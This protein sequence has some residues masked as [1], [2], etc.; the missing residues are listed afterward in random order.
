MIPSSGPLHGAI[1]ILP[2]L[3]CGDGVVDLRGP[4]RAGGESSQPERVERADAGDRAARYTL[5][6]LRHLQGA[7]GKDQPAPR[8]VVADDRA[9]AVGRVDAVF[10]RAL[11]VELLLQAR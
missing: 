5:R 10:Q 3:R 4:V 6:K 9:A 11:Q 2:E 8:N 1:G 7:A